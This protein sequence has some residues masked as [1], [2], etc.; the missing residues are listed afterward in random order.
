MDP[1]VTLKVILEPRLNPLVVRQLVASSL[2]ASSGPELH[3]LLMYSTVSKFVEVEL[4]V[5]IVAVPE[6]EG[7]QV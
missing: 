2:Y 5:W 3:W 1:A 4:Q 6:V 7:I